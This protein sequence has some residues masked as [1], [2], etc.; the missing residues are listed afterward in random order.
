MTEVDSTKVGKL[1]RL[2]G[3][4]KPGEVLAAVTAL[5]R[6]LESASLDVHDL[7]AIVEAGLRPAQQRPSWGPP[8][9]AA[10]NWQ[11]MAWFCRHHRHHLPEHHREFIEDLLL[12]RAQHQGRVTQWHLQELQRI[13]ASLQ[14]AV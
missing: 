13:V 12:G 8:E 7:A 11:S 10:D 1:L 2:L 14:E 3:S 6:T 5:K 9:P 4:D